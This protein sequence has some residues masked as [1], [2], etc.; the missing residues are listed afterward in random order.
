MSERDVPY[1]V[2]GSPIFQWLYV[3]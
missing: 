2:V 1:F 3:Q